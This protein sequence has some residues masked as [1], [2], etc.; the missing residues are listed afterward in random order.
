MRQ[1]NK[2]HA[3][4]RTGLAA[5]TLLLFAG[6]AGASEANYRTFMIGDRAAGM[7]GAAYSIRNIQS[8]KKITV[9]ATGKDANGR[10]SP[11]ILEGTARKWP[12]DLVLIAMGFTGPDAREGLQSL[13]E[14]RRPNFSDTCPL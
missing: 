5:G 7:G 10:M 6:W 11:K 2:Q 9:A 4:T 8:A 12:A 13:K 1:F 3:W 14:K